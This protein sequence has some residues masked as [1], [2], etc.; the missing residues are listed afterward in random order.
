MSAKNGKLKLSAV[1]AVFAALWIAFLLAGMGLKVTARF[2]GWPRASGDEL[3]ENRRL[4]QKPDFHSIPVKE[5]GKACE[6]WYND[7]FAKRYDVIKFYTTLHF[8]IFKSPVKRQVPGRGKWIFSRMGFEGPGGDVWPEVEDYMGVVKLD[9]KT[10]DDWKTLFEGR[11][12]WAEAHGIH[13]LE[14]LPPM[15]AEVHP[16]KMMPMISAHRKD[17]CREDLRAALA[18]STAS[19]NVL[20]LIESLRGEVESGREVYYEEDHH[21]NAYGCYCIYR[22]I[23]ARLRELWYPGIG[24]FPFYEDTVPQEVRDGAAPG[25]WVEDRRLVVSNPDMPVVGNPS[26]HIPAT[27]RSFPHGPVCVARQVPG[28]N[29][30]MGHDSFMRYPFSTW[31]SR[32]MSKFAV[33]LGKG[34]RQVSMLIFTRFD[35]KR[36]NDYIGRELPDVIIEQFSEGRLQFGTSIKGHDVLD[37]TMRKAAAWSHGTPVPASESLESAGVMAMAVLEK[38]DSSVPR[39]PVNVELRD[40][41]DAVISTVSADPGIRRAVFFGDI[42]PSSRYHVVISGGSAESYRLE[43]RR[44]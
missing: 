22:D 31:Y 43:F 25:C 34:F 44:R 24:D 38:V 10:V 21:E 27:N 14:V 26:L 42:S 30:L 1:D 13:Y 9:E 17:S 18:A 2:I 40:D 4:T 28:I 37:D 8:E 23:T 41:Q 20:F 39:T 36:L 33:P 6:A 5:W 32:D 3:A 12:A 7:H 16:E 11:V 19:S 15:K 29:V 35:T